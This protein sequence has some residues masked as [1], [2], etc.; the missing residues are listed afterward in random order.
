MKKALLALLLAYS[1]SSMAQLPRGVV[2]IDV[3]RHFMPTSFLKKQ[4]DELSHYGIPALHL[5]LTDA[6]G[7]RIEIKSH[8]ELTQMAA[9]RTAHKWEEWWNDGKRRYADQATGFGGYYTQDEL[10]N[11]VDYAQKRGVTIIPEIEF[12]G[13]SEE[14]LAALPQLACSGKPYSAADFCIGSDSTYQFLS[15]VLREI[16]SIFPSPYIHMGGDEAGG[17]LWK[18][19]PRCQGMTQTDAMERV[20]KIVRGLGRRMICWDEVLTDQLKDTSIV[21]MVWRNADVAK[22]A[23]QRGHEVIKAPG[24]FCYLD[25]YQ[26]RPEGSPRAMGGYL[27]V[28][29]IYAYYLEQLPLPQG[30]S[31]GMC[32]WTEYVPTPEHAER[33]LWPRALALSEALKANPKNPKEFRNWAEKECRLLRQRGMHAFNLDIEVGQR[34]EYCRKVRCLSTGREVTYNT[35]YHKAYPASGNTSLTDGQRGGWSN[36]DGRWQGFLGPVDIIVDLGKQRKIKRVSTTFLQSIGPEIFFPEQFQLLTSN[37]GKT[38]TTLY[39]TENLNNQKPDALMDYGWK[40][41][42]QTRFIRLK[43]ESPKRGGWIFLDEI[44]I[45]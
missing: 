9:W 21:I 44:M 37:D 41:K 25:K 10:R 15:D 42:T 5:H 4:I 11:L 36:T 14:V 16:T 26:D 7:W 29:S 39:E 1:L 12:P 33:M 19:C 6:A 23:R 2:M 3:S 24:R 35:P 22:K 27:P 30:E 13:H 18:T 17:R 34:K 31:L 32:L 28:D 38:W 45:H 40:G 20:S 43:S 8:P